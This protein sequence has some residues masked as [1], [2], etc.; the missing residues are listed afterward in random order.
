MHW[1]AH[2]PVVLTAVLILF[3]LSVSWWISGRI[4]KSHEKD[5]HKQEAFRASVQQARE[6]DIWSGFEDAHE[7]CPPVFEENDTWGKGAQQPAL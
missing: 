2:H 4:L 7:K 1:I 5:R 6:N 3:V